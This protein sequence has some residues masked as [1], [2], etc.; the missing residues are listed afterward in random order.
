MNT[1]IAAAGKRSHLLG[2]CLTVPVV[3]VFPLQ[4]NH[5]TMAGHSYEHDV[6]M[7]SRYGFLGSIDANTGDTSLGWDTDQV[8]HKTAAG[9]FL[10]NPRALVSASLMS[11]VCCLCA[12]S[13]VLSV[14]VSSLCF[15]RTARASC[16][17]L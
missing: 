1:E 5:T 2:S 8:R 4:P 12:C 7:A 10:S 14:F 15:S 13:C 9:R 6:E 11:D 3:R 16:A 17:S